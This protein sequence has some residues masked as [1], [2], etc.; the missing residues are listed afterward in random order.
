MSRRAI[1]KLLQL[2]V[3]ASLEGSGTES[4]VPGSE[5]QASVDS[6]PATRDHNPFRLLAEHA[7]PELS[8]EERPRAER[9]ATNASRCNMTPKVSAQ[10]VRR[11]K[12]QRA[13]T[14]QRTSTSSHTD[15]EELS[16]SLSRSNVGTSN[17]DQESSGLTEQDEPDR[18]SEER[19]IAMTSAG[20]KL[21]TIDVGK[22]NAD[23]ELR[24]FFGRDVVEREQVH[25]ERAVS[26][27][28][29]RRGTTRRPRHRLRHAADAL[30]IGTGT[31]ARSVWVSPKPSWSRS[32]PGLSMEPVLEWRLPRPIFRYHYREPYL[33][34]E[35][36]FDQV[37]RSGDHHLMIE[38][39]WTYPFHVGALLQLAEIYRVFGE[40]ERENECIERALFT[41]ENS[42]HPRYRPGA[43]YLPFQFTANQPCYKALCLGA[44]RARRKGSY[45]TAMEIAKLLCTLDP[46][47]DESRTNL[48]PWCDPVGALLVVDAY[49]L[50]AKEW[51]WILQCM[52]SEHPSAAVLRQLPNWQYSY[53][54]ALWKDRSIQE[55]K[56]GTTSG[57]SKEALVKER[58]TECVQ[59]YPYLAHALVFE[60][61]GVA[62][63]LPLLLR[64]TVAGYVER[65]ATLWR[66]SPL[67]ESMRACLEQYRTERTQQA[68]FP[69]SDSHWAE[70]IG[71]R[72]NPLH[73]EWI[74][75]SDRAGGNPTNWSDMPVPWD[76][77]AASTSPADAD[78]TAGV[79]SSAQSVSGNGAEDAVQNGPNSSPTDATDE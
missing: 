63:S 31:L 43:A 74:H 13:P 24:R 44:E 60:P 58:L 66:N 19:W 28:R 17:S 57:R 32:T 3:D 37:V 34:L 61:S 21:F 55:T 40:A 7:H 70:G 12:P 38:F 62:H 78:P 51:N 53:L 67:T 39:S 48:R 22:L 45:R 41:L 11:S 77:L 8:D 6:G 73:T 36:G 30:V 26:G 33:S 72:T 20:L 5:Q 49:A 69:E 75:P 42:Q 46:P 1:R 52:E 18:T 35:E 14:G 29:E 27:A 59:Q 56:D 23:N 16:H 25:M 71:I 47:V 54:Y 79:D 68:P 64:R 50:L 2:E 10:Q 4:D 9:P 76:D 15:V 65:T